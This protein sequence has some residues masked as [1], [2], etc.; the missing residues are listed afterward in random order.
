VEKVPDALMQR[1]DRLAHPEKTLEWGDPL[2]TSTPASIAIHQLAVRT[3]ALTV[4][5][6][7]LA[8]ELETLASEVEE[9]RGAEHPSQL[10]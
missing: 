9:L 1:V 4:A 10:R 7:D 2:L 6:R 3:Q 5:V 8:L